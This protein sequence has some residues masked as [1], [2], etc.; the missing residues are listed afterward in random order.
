MWSK[1]ASE[2]DNGQTSES[3][4]QISITISNISPP[5]IQLIL[6]NSEPTT[7][8]YFSTSESQNQSSTSHD[9][10]TLILP[11]RWSLKSVFENVVKWPVQQVPKSKR[12]KYQKC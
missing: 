1:C 9:T 4:T 12:K 5:P 6:N 8:S 10:N 3:T 7:T 2:I 11:T